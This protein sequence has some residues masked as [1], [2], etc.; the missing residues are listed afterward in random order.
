MKHKTYALINSLN[1]ERKKNLRFK[2]FK[3]IRGLKM[4]KG[5][6]Q[7]EKREILKS[8]SLRRR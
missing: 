8:V 2:F 5:V 3:I 6:E 1:S 4:W 7:G